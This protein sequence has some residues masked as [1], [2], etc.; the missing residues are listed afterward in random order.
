MVDGLGDHDR[1]IVDHRVGAAGVMSHDDGMVDRRP[2]VG[3]GCHNWYT[4][5][6]GE[7]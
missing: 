4:R 5:G 1:T 2:D 3:V 6:L 7:V